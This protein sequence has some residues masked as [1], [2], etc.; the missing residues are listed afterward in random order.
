MKM[1]GAKPPADPGA[2]SRSFGEKLIGMTPV[3]M[4]VLA[5]L[6]A[7]ISSSEMTQAQFHRALAAEQQSKASDQWAFFQAKR[8]RG[9]SL[10]LTVDL[11]PS[12]G[13]LQ[14][15]SIDRSLARLESTCQRL[16]K[17]AGQ[18]AKASTDNKDL[19]STT[20]ATMQTRLAETGARLDESLQEIK[21]AQKELTC[22]G[23]HK[24]LAELVAAKLPEKKTAEHPAAIKE[25]MDAVG[26]RNL[27]EE[28]RERVGHLTLEQLKEAMDAEDAISQ[29]F[30][31]VVK[32]ISDLGDDL[33]KHVAKARRAIN[34]C[35]RTAREIQETDGQSEAFQKEVAQLLAA[36]TAAKASADE[37]V[38]D[39]T[40]ARHIFRA[41]SYEREARNNQELAKLYEVQRL[42]SD[43]IADR[44]RHRSRLFFY[45]MLASQAGVTIASL[46]LAV[47]HKSV[48]WS[49]ATVAGVGA[50]LFSAY[51]FFYF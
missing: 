33:A 50:M 38:H 19:E 6:L 1:F 49:T 10:E 18:F 25:A 21:I 35:W 30:N 4:T 27:P 29:A 20:R 36:A 2:E 34:A 11:L 42:R 48:L 44:H 39:L 31:G 16:Q 28:V 9:S 40:A 45:G 12:A 8:I 7:G 5:T 14:L 47:R 37:L 22:E 17:Q 23:N 24:T 13:D 26:S 46:A 41:R 43:V 32:P 51:V 15:G 3:F